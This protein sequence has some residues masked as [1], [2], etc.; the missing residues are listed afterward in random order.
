MVPR[1]RGK[2]TVAGRLPADDPEQMQCA[3]RLYNQLYLEK[4]S[5]QNVQFTAGYFSQASQLGLLQLYGLFHQQQMMGVVG[6][7]QLEQT[8]TVPIVVNA[9]QRGVWAV[10]SWLSRKVYLPLLRRYQL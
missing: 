3:E 8:I 6:M 9:Y 7:V 1:Y 4:Y 2:H 5:R 10:I